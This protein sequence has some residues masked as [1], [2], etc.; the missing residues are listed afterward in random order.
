MIVLQKPKLAFYN[1]AV[2][3]WE[4][5]VFH[6]SNQGVYLG[7]NV[8]EGLKAYWQP[9]GSIGVVAMRPHYER[10]KRSASLLHI[11][12]EHD[13]QQFD[14]AVHALVEALCVPEN[15]IW[16]RATLYI[17]EGFWGENQESDLVL[18]AYQCRKEAPAP[19]HVGVSTWRRA[20]DTVLPSRIKTSTN[21]QVTR[22]AKIEGRARGYG[23]MI[24]LNSHDRVSEAGGS[25]VLAVRDGV[26][27]TPPASEGTLESLT[28][29]LIEALAKDSGI[30]FVR[31]PLDR[32]ELYIAD[33]LGL[34]GTLSE[35]TL[36]ASIDGRP[37]G[38]GSGILAGLSE[39]YRSAVMGIDPHP[40]TRLSVRR[41]RRSGKRRAEH[42]VA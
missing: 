29:D 35:L 23:E 1:G 7:I 9:D 16:I 5:A 37:V 28:V 14:D 19:L 4:G 40:M 17:T 27:I 12:F 38:P 32:T 3:P 30:P 34:A 10:L 22:L 8:F 39:R 18:T 33:E 21:Y 15:D 13:F 31:R 36:I 42:A 11:P 2:R 6:V 25:C 41:H 26:V 20:P 24:L